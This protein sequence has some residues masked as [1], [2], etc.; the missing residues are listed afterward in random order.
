MTGVEEP[1]LATGRF[2]E[3]TSTSRLPALEATGGLAEFRVVLF[4][5]FRRSEGGEQF[6]W[7]TRSQGFPFGSSG[8]LINL[9]T[10]HNLQ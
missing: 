7:K 9:E 10:S 1:K 8:S 6:T 3:K 5:K 4:P 2:S